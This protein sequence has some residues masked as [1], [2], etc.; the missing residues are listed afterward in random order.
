M[1]R[2][3]AI[4]IIDLLKE[5]GVSFDRGLSEIEIQ[6]IKNTF[7]IQFP[8]DLKMLLKTN[9]PVSQGFV[10]WRYGINS[11]KGEREISQR[12]HAPFEGILYSIKLNSF[13]LEAWDEIPDTFE[14]KKSRFE[15]EYKTKPKLIPIYSH[16]YIPE[17]PMEKGN[18]VFSVHGIDI[19]Y[20]GFD[21]LNYFEKEFKI[22][23]PEK[24]GNITYPKKIDFWSDFDPIDGV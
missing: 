21:L 19:I 24:F 13:W 1:N 5:N 16:R 22:K 6:E 4:L 12:L 18:P 14:E 23:L 8:E 2:N 10:H 20:Y 3:Q 11:K 9:H 17:K 7:N 15:V